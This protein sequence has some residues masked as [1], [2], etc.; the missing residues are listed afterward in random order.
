[1]LKD[2]VDF[3][4]TIDLL[5]K[6]LDL[7]IELQDDIMESDKI[8]NSFKSIENNLNTLYEKT[9]YLEDIIDYTKTF[10]TMKID[11]YCNDINASIKSIEDISKIDKNLGYI[12]YNVPFIKNTIEIKDRNK[13]FKIT[14]CSIKNNVLTLSNRI[15]DSYDYFSIIMKCEQKPHI[16]NISTIKEDNFYR[17]IY[18]EEKPISNGIVETITVYLNEPKEINELNIN[19][20]NCKI[21]NIRFVYINGIEEQAGNLITGIEL[22]SRVV[23]HIK[24]DIECTNYNIIQYVLDKDKVTKDIYNSIKEFEYPNSQNIEDKISYESI[25][26]KIEYNSLTKE[27]NIINYRK[28]VENTESIIMYVYNFGF[29][30]FNIN[31]SVLYEDNYFLSNPISI[32]SFNENEYIQLYVEDNNSNNSSIEYYIVDG[33]IDV[34]IMPIGLDYIDNERIFP[35]TDLRFIE[36]N[37][38]M[39]FQEKIIKKNGLELPISLEE[40]K[41]KYDARYSISYTPQIKNTYTPLNNTIRVK[42]IIRTFGDNYDSI[43]YINNINIRKFGG[44]AL[45]TNLY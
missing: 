4:Y 7:N 25:I 32:G 6:D 40:S 8:N 12:D 5:N 10:L 11:N 14:P 31:R 17:S 23:T 20:V 9:R 34:P 24:F 22:E 45:W 41:L 38:I 44:D 3:D 35:E 39:S 42:A 13:N 33:D 36:S 28:D 15:N 19:P 29:D 21:N 37:D 16:N 1:M 43:P 18:L 27:S 26:K 2:S 30:S